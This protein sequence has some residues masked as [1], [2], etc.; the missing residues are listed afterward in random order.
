MDRKILNKCFAM[1]LIISM[2][3]LFVGSNFYYHTHVIDGEEI[4][5]SHPYSPTTSHSHSSTSLA[6][7][8]MLTHLTYLS[9]AVFAALFIVSTRKFSTN[10]A[11]SIFVNLNI[12]GHK[13]LR[14]PPVL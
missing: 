8:D 9:V 3:A 11:T 10:T 6:M 1:L 7:I 2:T 4:T 14:A 5:H 13:Q 12:I